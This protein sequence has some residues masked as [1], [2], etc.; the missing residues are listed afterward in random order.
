MTITIRTD[1]EYRLRRRMSARIFPLIHSSRSADRSLL[2]IAYD[3]A[4]RGTPV[5]PDLKY[6]PGIDF[7]VLDEMHEE[8]EQLLRDSFADLESDLAEI[9][10]VRADIDDAHDALRASVIRGRCR[11]P[12][13][14][15]KESV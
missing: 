8:M 9:L 5:C 7:Q 14:V 1:L 11:R 13:L 12:F 15:E 6:S 3:D 10:A 2:L 4:A